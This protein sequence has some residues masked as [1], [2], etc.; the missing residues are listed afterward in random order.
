M[1]ARATVSVTID[2][3]QE[4]VAINRWF[5]RWG[6]RMRCSD[7][8]GCGCCV[9]IWEVEAPLEAFDEL[10]APLHSTP[11]VTKDRDESA[12]D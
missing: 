2:N 9:D 3:E 8:Q 10:P 4:I 5:Q 1:Q 12:I 7:N 6:S 11:V